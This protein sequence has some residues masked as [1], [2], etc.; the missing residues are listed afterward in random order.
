MFQVGRIEQFN[1]IYSL[2]YI[3][4]MHIFIID[5]ASIELIVENT[6]FHHNPQGQY[7]ARNSRY[8]LMW[9]QKFHPELS[10]CLAIHELIHCHL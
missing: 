6:S 5:A 1:S 8:P 2:K 4:M 10:H 3:K 9:R 7:L